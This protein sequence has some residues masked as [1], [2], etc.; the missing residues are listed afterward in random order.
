METTWQP[1][2]GW[3][4]TDDGTLTIRAAYGYL[5]DW[6]PG[7]LFKQTLLVDG[8]RLRE[9]NVHQPVLARA[10]AG[11]SRHGHEPLSLVSDDL[12]LEA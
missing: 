1:V 5:Y 8:S 11:Q 6:I 2:F 9:L 12:A 7:N 4:P 10:A 3:S